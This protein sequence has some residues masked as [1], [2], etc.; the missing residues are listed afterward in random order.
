[1]EKC[2]KFKN[3]FSFNGLVGSVFCLAVSVTVIR[4]VTVA[5]AAIESCSLSPFLGFC[6]ERLSLREVASKQNASKGINMSLKTFRT[7][8][9]A[10]EF[11][12]AC[13]GLRLPGY[14]KDQILRASSSVALNVAEGSA[15]PTAP[16]Q[17]RYYAIALGSFSS[18]D[19]ALIKC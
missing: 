14:L 4:T 3:P 13:K 11:H 2:F 18:G 10:V 8:Q 6:F 7:Y 19:K 15:K 1:M 5:V 12:L 9:L 16:D 17:R